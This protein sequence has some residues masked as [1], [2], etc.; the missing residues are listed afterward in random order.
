M[1][2][3]SLAE[4]PLVYFIS[5]WKLASHRSAHT[6]TRPRTVQ[7][8]LE[9]TMKDKASKTD[10]PSKQTRQLQPLPTLPKWEV[11]LYFT[12]WTLHLFYA[13]YIAWKASSSFE[14][15]IWQGYFEPG[16]RFLNN[17][18]RDSANY[19][20][21]SWFQNLPFQVVTF[22]LHTLWMRLVDALFA[23]RRKAELTLFLIWILILWIHLGLIGIFVTFLQCA[24]LLAVAR[25]TQWKPAVWFCACGLLLALMTEWYP[26]GNE[27][28]AAYRFAIYI[29]YNLLH[30]ISFCMHDIDEQ[31]R[32]S[33]GDKKK[34]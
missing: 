2:M 15:R 32:E 23:D 10:A 20:W 22:S 30:G 16:W 29:A 18:R 24:L 13:W 33:A 21:T 28:D 25:F 8:K 1:Q 3:S 12:I 9:P 26:L 11:T 27:P 14:H 31:R 34:E 17:R 5:N 7:P 19:E 6:V 4:A